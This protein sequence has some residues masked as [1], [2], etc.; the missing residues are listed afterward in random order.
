MH[1]HRL[2]QISAWA[3][4][5]E[6]VFNEVNK[7]N[8]MSE[9][10]KI[11]SDSEI[12]LMLPGGGREIDRFLLRSLNNLAGSINEHI[13]HEEQFLDALGTPESVRVR[14]QWIETQIEKQRVKNRMMER[15]SESSVSW[16]LIAVLGFLAWAV[17]NHILEIFRAK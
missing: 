11:Y 14:V 6:A 3:R 2:R 16:A 7:D 9:E 10:H 15:V 17:W 8:V 1:Q 13:K 12:E 4:T 5:A